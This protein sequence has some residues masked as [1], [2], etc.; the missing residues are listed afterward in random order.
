MPSILTRSLL[1]TV[2]RWYRLRF[3]VRKNPN[4]VR[5]SP[6]HLLHRTNHNPLRHVI[7]I[8]LPGPRLS[9][10][11]LDSDFRTQCIPLSIFNLTPDA[12]FQKRLPT[13]NDSIASDLPHRPNIIY[14]PPPRIRTYPSEAQ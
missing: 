4:S 5:T 9:L 12:S 11:F 6:I 13:H 2:Q 7:I 14:A 1:T 8:G 3:Q 10:Q